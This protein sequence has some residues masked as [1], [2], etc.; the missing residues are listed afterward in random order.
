MAG[1]SLTM[2]TA[3]LLHRN[4]S[5]Y[6]SQCDQ[7]NITV[8]VCVIKISLYNKDRR[9][10]GGSAKQGSVVA[11]RQLGWQC[12]DLCLSAPPPKRQTFL[13]VADMSRM[14]ARHVGDILLCR[15]I[16]WL[17]VSCQGI[18]LPTQFPTCKQ[19]SVLVRYFLLLLHAC[20]N[21]VAIKLL[22]HS[23]PFDQRNWFGVIRGSL[24]PLVALGLGAYKIP[25]LQ[26]KPQ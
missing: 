23:P 12:R 22:S 21:L 3:C 14:S 13:P 15:P 18:M 17:S 8:M 16:F 5:E 7:G 6:T 24:I 9:F 19:E 4:V 11:S 25:Q 10:S 26:A 1:P 2:K 20:R